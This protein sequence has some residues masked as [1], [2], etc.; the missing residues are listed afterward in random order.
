M[1][2][3]ILRTTSSRTECKDKSNNDKHNKTITSHNH[4]HKHKGCQHHDYHDVEIKLVDIKP[5]P[6]VDAFNS[7]VERSWLWMRVM[8]VKMMVNK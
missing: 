7:N 4:Y 5:P 6:R 1:I 8:M 2:E 3:V